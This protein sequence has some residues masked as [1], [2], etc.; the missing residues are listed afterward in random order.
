MEKPKNL[1]CMTHRHEIRGGLLEETGVPG[2]GSR[3]GKIGITVIA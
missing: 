1:I 3:G 2:G